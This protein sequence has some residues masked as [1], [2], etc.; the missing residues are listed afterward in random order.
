MTGLAAH[1]LA[2]VRGDRLLFE[3]V[4]F[5]VPPGGALRV[6]G[7]NGAGKSSLLRML[8]G[9]LR[10]AAGSIV[11][12]ERTAWLGHENA[13]KLDSALARE[14][15]FWARLDGAGEAECAAA[16]RR[17]DLDALLDL[18]VR[19]L[20]NGQRRRAALARIAA[21]GAT[22]WLL[23]EP[24]VGLDR[25]SVAALEAAIAD[26]RAGGGMVVVATHAALTLPGSAQLSLEIHAET[27]MLDAAV[28]N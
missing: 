20:S 27:A 26:H 17:F 2:C 23:D 1:T 11:K 3:G 13:L 6:T 18:D 10:P 21:S 5:T 7:P 22:L 4:S 16:A 24:E 15:G 19:L 14:L 12:P 28:N 9:L 8:A 25:G